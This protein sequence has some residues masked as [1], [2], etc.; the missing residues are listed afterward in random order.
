VAR[1]NQLRT[2]LREDFGRLRKQINKAMQQK[3]HRQRRS[4]RLQ[5]TRTHTYKR[6]WETSAYSSKLFKHLSTIPNN[7]GN[8]NSGNK[9]TLRNRR[10][11]KHRRMKSK[12]NKSR[13]N[14]NNNNNNYNYNNNHNHRSQVRGSMKQR[15]SV[16]AHGRRGYPKRGMLYV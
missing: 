15:S 3:P 5:S 14:S 7:N 10:S 8:N 12:N 13:I 1:Q 9:R 16:S 4:V 6:K 2:R 11:L